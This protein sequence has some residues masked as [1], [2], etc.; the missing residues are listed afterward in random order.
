MFIALWKTARACVSKGLVAYL[1][2]K[3]GSSFHNSQGNT[4]ETTEVPLG[5]V[6][7]IKKLSKWNLTKASRPSL[8]K[9]RAGCF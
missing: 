4:A 2:T 7:K 6:I 9:K 8:C 1:S 3:F 5:T